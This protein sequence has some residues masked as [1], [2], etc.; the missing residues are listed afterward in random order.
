[1]TVVFC[2]IILLPSLLSFLHHVHLSGLPE[3]AHI[4]IEEEEKV[5][6]LVVLDGRG[7]GLVGFGCQDIGVNFFDVFHRL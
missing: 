7:G 2:L 5:L 1:M 3:N 4:D 6:V